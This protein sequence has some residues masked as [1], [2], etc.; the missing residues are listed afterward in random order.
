[1]SHE[2]M[3]PEALP[4]AV[5]PYQPAFAFTQL[6]ID[7]RAIEALESLPEFETADESV[8]PE[9]AE[10]NTLRIIAEEFS[11]TIETTYPVDRIQVNQRVTLTD[12]TVKIYFHHIFVKPRQIIATRSV[13]L[14]LTSHPEPRH[15]HNRLETNFDVTAR[16][17]IGPVS[18]P[19]WTGSPQTLLHA[20]PPVTL[21]GRDLFGFYQITI[22]LSS[23]SNLNLSRTVL[24]PL[25]EVNLPLFSPDN[26]QIVIR[27]PFTQ[28]TANYTA[29]ATYITP[30][31]V[32][33]ETPGLSWPVVNTH[34]PRWIRFSNEETPPTSRV[35]LI[36]LP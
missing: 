17:D 26:D 13:D 11:S 16:R 35:N 24:P 5:G 4:S 3:T 2:D 31:S 21:R 6:T 22:Q 25:G 29:R 32:V 28:V 34:I 1:M 10:A 20:R 36:G 18:F 27:P 19:P 23:E 14:T 12:P 15:L 8:V 30:P 33:S 7:D 9:Y